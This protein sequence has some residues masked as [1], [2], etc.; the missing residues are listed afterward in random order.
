MEGFNWPYKVR[1]LVGKNSIVCCDRGIGREFEKN[2]IFVK[3]FF[4]VA[5]VL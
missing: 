2:A 5:L 4:G 1:E 3:M